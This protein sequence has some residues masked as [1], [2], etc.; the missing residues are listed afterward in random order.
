MKTLLVTTLGA[1]VITLVFVAGGYTL[2]RIEVN[3]TVSVVM[4]GIAWMVSLWLL[5]ST[6]FS[7]K[8]KGII[9]WRKH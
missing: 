2:Y 3:F 5:Y 4:L 7:K 8:K 6:V 9:S 1:F